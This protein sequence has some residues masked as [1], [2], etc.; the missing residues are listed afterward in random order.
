MKKILNILLIFL[1]IGCT[2]NKNLQIYEDYTINSG[3]DTIISYKLYSNS[4]KTFSEE[5]K[6]A[7]NLFTYYHQLF[8]KYNNYEINN[9]KTINDNAGIQPITVDQEIINLL[10]LSKQYSELSNN[11]FNITLGSVLKIWHDVREKALANE[12]YT[13]PSQ[14]E[15]NEAYLKTGWDKVIIDDENNTVYLTESGVSLDV[16]AVA[17]GYAT[18]KVGEM[19]IE[20]GFTNGF[21][22]A[23]G[24]ILFLG[25]KPDNVAWNAGIL[26]PTLNNSSNSLVILQI[27]DN[28][29]FVTSGDYQ[30]YFIHENEIMH[31][32]IDPDTLFPAKHAKSITILTKDSG[33]ADIL[34]TT[35]YTMT[36]QEGLGLINSLKSNGLDIEAVWIYDQTKEIENENY[37]VKDNFYVLSTNNEL[38]K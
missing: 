33:I 11:Q 14:S 22:N 37:I 3:F 13:L 28:S 12:S 38:I 1:L 27:N 19:L 18:Q 4:E 15:L 30:R 24:N 5:I 25:P 23:G 36:Y 10:N 8:D 34:S 35:L 32:I 7:N 29:S 16:G 2:S 6:K 21:I 9:I 26:S 17:K 20:D 31:H